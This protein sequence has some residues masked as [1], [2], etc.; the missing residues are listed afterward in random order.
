MEFGP[1]K[2]EGGGGDS[3]GNSQVEPVQLPPAL[4]QRRAGS[5]VPDGGGD[6]PVGGWKIGLSG[7]SVPPGDCNCVKHS[8]IAASASA[9]G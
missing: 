2:E 1:I 7:G 3:V 5:S 8:R 4:V 9:D 6:V